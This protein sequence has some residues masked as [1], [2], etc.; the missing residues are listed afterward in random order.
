MT[1]AVFKTL[2]GLTKDRHITTKLVFPNKTGTNR[3]R[4]N[5]S[6]AFKRACKRAGIE[7]FRF[8]DLRHDFGSNLVQ[9]GISIYSVKE[10]M[11][12]KDVRT[13]QRYAHLSPDKL[14]VDIAA[15]DKPMTQIF[16]KPL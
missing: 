8:H 6:N 5:V 15:L 7:D 4:H 10:L 11:G 3:C 2:K 14:K 9:R 13:T 12:H 16:H 1:H